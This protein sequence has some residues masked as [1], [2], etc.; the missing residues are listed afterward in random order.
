MATSVV[1]VGMF[2]AEQL[3]AVP[4]LTAK[5]INTKIGTTFMQTSIAAVPFLPLRRARVKQLSPPR[6]ANWEKQA[7]GE[8]ASGWYSFFFGM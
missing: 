2:G 6:E 8:S 4:I 1:K 3:C 5:S 7:W